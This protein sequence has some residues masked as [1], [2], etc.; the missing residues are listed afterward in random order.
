MK[1]LLTVTTGIEAGAGLLLTASPSTT[2]WLL[3]GT[4]L[5]T[6]TALAVGRVAGAALLGLAVACWFARRDEPA[7]AATGV[8]AGML[9]YNAAVVAILVYAGTISGLLGVALW[10]GVVLHLAMSVW[11]IACLRKTHVKVVEQPHVADS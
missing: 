5:D 11:C 1:P 4:S 9:T 2:A 10:P 6:P 3:L 7:H 8:M